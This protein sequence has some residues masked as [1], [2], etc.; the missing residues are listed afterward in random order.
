M[1]YIKH[2]ACLFLIWAAI[3]SPGAAQ[4]HSPLSERTVLNVQIEQ[5]SE[6]IVHGSSNINKF[7]CVNTLLN[8]DY[9]H[10]FLVQEHN[11]EILVEDAFLKV[12]VS[13]FDCGIKK[14]TKDFYKLVEEEDFP[15]WTLRLLTISRGD[16]PGHF[17]AL[18]NVTLAGKSKD[19]L[20][21]IVSEGDD[22]AVCKGSIVVS[23]EEFDLE[24]PSKILGL[25]KVDPD[26]RIEFK[27]GMQVALVP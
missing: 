5:G 22:P 14:L 11:E 27:V 20:V 9:T 26:V 24:P 16:S 1:T 10:T 12:N 6:M 4:I 8:E 7:Q 18:I 3:P 19:L 15:F 21:P 13:E 17:N 25:I 2:L 23:I